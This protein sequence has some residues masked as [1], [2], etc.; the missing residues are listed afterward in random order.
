MEDEHDALLWNYSNIFSRLMESVLVINF[1][2]CRIFKR[3]LQLVL[4]KEKSILGEF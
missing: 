2:S 4:K 3:K 1:S